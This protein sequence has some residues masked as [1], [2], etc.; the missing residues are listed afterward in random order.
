MADEEDRLLAEAEASREE[1]R[2]LREE[3]TE[4]ADEARAEHERS[5]PLPERGGEPWAKTSS[6]D[7]DS[8]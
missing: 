3:G 6:G 5:D 8:P 2:R 7:T 4:A 1:T